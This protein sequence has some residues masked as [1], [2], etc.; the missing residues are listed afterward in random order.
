[1]SVNLVTGSQPA[2]DREVDNKK[3][4]PQEYQGKPAQGEASPMGFVDDDEDRR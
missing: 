4:D 3:V 1:M 2:E